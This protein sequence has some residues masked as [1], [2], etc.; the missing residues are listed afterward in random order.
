MIG[1]KLTLRVLLSFVTLACLNFI[2]Y[3][4]E[5]TAGLTFVTLASLPP[6][7][8]ACS[9]VGGVENGET[10]CKEDEE[11][12]CKEDEESPSNQSV[13]FGSK[14]H[15]SNQHSQHYTYKEGAMV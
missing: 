7:G 9:E 3:H 1:P 6:A 10:R 14:T 4:Y 5:L 2:T 13:S 8:W 11:T 15:T 12:R